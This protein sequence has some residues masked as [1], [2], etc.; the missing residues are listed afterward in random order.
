[1]TGNRLLLVLALAALAAAAPAAAQVTATPSEAVAGRLLAAHNGERARLGV[2][3][4][5]WNAKLAE[6]AR[7]W[8]Q[9]LAVADMI[10]HSTAAA[11]GGE[12]ENLWFG[13]KGDYTPEEMVGF[14][15]DESKEF[16][17]G[18]FPDV[19]T[20]GRWED[21]GHYTQLVWKDTREVG[22]SIVSNQR[23]DVLVCRYMPAGNFIGQPVFDY[24]AVPAAK[25]VPVVAAG[26]STAEA[27]PAAPTPPAPKKRV[28]KK[29]R[30]GG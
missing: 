1:M 2:K 6:H 4:L 10:E 7:K 30:R 17:R 18:I 5:A 26:A 9:T 13:T 22:C 28:S 25:T 15:I 3:P 21:V 14:F 19:S 11:D 20:T 8:A 16:K 27:S 24:A 29:R 23:R 12:G